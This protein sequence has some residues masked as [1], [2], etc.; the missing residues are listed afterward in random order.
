MDINGYQPQNF[1]GQY[2]GTLTL[3]DALAHSVNTITV[4]LA[5]EVGIKKVVG[6]GAARSA[7]L[8]RWKPMP[9]WRWAPAKS[10]RWN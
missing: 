6:G 3:A 8:R 1:G 2:Y 7:S 5:Q 10:R 9:R 4:N